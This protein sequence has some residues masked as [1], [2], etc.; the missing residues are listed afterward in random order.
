VFL[1]AIASQVALA[2]DRARLTELQ[3]QQEEQEK[4]RLLAEVAELR[5]AL[6]RTQIVYRSSTMDSL[7]E[8]VRRVAPDRRDRAHHRRERHRQGALRPRAAR[9]VSRRGQP[10]VVVDCGAIPRRS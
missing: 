2:L 8:R 10:F 6:Q 7:L 4:K 3:R 9:A 5:T 1:E